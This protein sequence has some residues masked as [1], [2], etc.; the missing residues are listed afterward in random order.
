M[1]KID[2]YNYF[3]LPTASATVTVI[4]LSLFDLN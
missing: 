2:D 4:D 1:I 3:S